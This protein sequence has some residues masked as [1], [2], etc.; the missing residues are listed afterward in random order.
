MGWTSKI[1]G[2]SKNKKLDTQTKQQKALTNEYL[3]ALQGGATTNVNTLQDY[4]EE[5]YNPYDAVGGT[6]LVN[7]MQR[8][9]DADRQGQINALKGGHMNRFSMASAAATGNAYDQAQKQ[10]TD[11]AYKDL[12]TQAKFGQQAYDNQNQAIGN[13]FNQSNALLG[14]NTFQNQPQVKKGLTDYIGQT[15]KATTDIANMGKTIFG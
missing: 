2:G 13:L 8:N 15:S 5:G 7:Q 3:N 6:A 14:L 1:F 10:Q 9:I 4:A 12:L 11:L